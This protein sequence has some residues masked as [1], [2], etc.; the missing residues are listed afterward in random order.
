MG[1]VDG[2]V[3]PWARKDYGRFWGGFGEI[4]WLLGSKE[5]LG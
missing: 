1:K 4:F 2:F 3:I 5:S